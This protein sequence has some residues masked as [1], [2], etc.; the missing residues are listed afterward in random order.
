M[1]TPIRA[2]GDQAA[3]PAGSHALSAANALYVD[4]DNSTQV[5]SVLDTMLGVWHAFL[6]ILSS[7]MAKQHMLQL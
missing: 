3:S 1:V 2:G 5:W 4:S 6:L 7:S